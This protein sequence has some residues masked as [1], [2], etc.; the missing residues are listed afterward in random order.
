MYI[1]HYPLV[2]KKKMSFTPKRQKVIEEDV[3][4]LLK[5]GFIRENHYMDWIANVVM[6]KVNDKWRICIDNKT[7]PKDSYHLP[8]IDQLVDATSWHELLSL[9]DIFLGYNQIEW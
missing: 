6:V 7:Y 8:R 2:K 3:D 1:P 9:M 4:K 5:V